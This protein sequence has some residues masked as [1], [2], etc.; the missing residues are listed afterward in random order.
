MRLGAC[1]RRAKEE[2]FDAF[3]TTITYSP[4]QDHDLVK[5]TGAAMAQKYQVEFFYHDWR[6]RYQEG[7]EKC[8]ALG[9]YRQK[10]CGCIYSEKER[11]EKK[12][13]QYVK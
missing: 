3:A 11:N 5:S 1:A 7:K 8:H 12:L 9:L 10:Y 4:H 6:S 2:N 13:G